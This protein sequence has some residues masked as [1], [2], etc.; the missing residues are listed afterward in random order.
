MKKFLAVI[1]FAA[2]IASTLAINV[3]AAPPK[4]YPILR[5]AT[6][7]VID[8]VVNADEWQGAKVSYVDNTFDLQWGDSDNPIKADF[9]LMWDDAGLYF[10]AFA[11]DDP[12]GFVKL[13]DGEENTKQGDGV[14]LLLDP[15][16]TVIDDEI[17]QIAH[18]GY[19]FDIYPQ[20]PYYEHWIYPPE[21]GGLYDVRAGRNV[22]TKGW[23]SD[24]GKSWSVEAFLPWADLQKGGE[25]PMPNFN[26]AEGMKMSIGF[27]VMEMGDSQSGFCT[28]DGWETVKWDTGILS[29]NTAGIVP[30]EPAPEENPPAAAE[31][32]PADTPEA[33]APPPPV[34]TAPQTGDAH[35]WAFI[36]LAAAACTAVKSRKFRAK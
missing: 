35:I 22:V 5:A 19:I 16:Y 34:S 9:Y 2:L 14:Q 28:F 32:T 21:E 12:S 31:D 26:V 6:P 8:G 20:T 30:P 29:M 25:F 7:P 23:V 33:A 24:D 4:E 15:S 10:A 13:A 3:N 36:V 18:N 11:K 1:I 17:V 27:I